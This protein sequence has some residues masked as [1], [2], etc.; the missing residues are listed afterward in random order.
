MYAALSC[1]PAIL[2]DV[3][4]DLAVAAKKLNQFLKTHDELSALQT[5]RQ[6]LDSVQEELSKAGK[7]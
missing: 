3:D 1:K 4:C 2:R 6:Q 5:T 7:A